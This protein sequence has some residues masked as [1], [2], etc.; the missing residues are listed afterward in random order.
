MLA[1]QKSFFND[2]VNSERLH[3][4]FTFVRNS[5]GSYFNKDGV[6]VYVAN[7]IPRIEFDPITKKCLGVKVEPTA[8]NHLLNSRISTISRV[9]ITDGWYML[10][11]AT[12]GTGDNW[13][14]GAASTKITPGSYPLYQ[15]SYTSSVRKAYNDFQSFSIFAKPTLG[16]Q[17][18]I[19]LSDGANQLAFAIYEFALDGTATLISESYAEEKLIGNAGVEKVRKDGWW[20]LSL[21]AMVPSA[22]TT[23]NIS[24][25]VIFDGVTEV[26]GS[27]LENMPYCTSYIRTTTST[28]LRG[29][30]NINIPAATLSNFTSPEGFTIVTDFNNRTIANCNHIVAGPSLVYDSLHRCQVLVHDFEYN[31]FV[32]QLSGRLAGNGQ[33]LN[34]RLAYQTSRSAWK[35]LDRVKS[36][37]GVGGGRRAAL[38][39]MGKTSVEFLEDGDFRNYPP[40]MYLGTYNGTSAVS[41]TTTAELAVSGHFREIGII[42]NRVS[43][44]VLRALSHQ[45]IDPALYS[46][47]GFVQPIA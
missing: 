41:P 17:V 24:I 5:E 22:N 3:P 37:L 21:M 1:P 20:R 18:M 39:M 43:D 6:L 13:V 34:A 33:T 19:E 25:R 47:F 2:I 30:D 9:G 10:G 38:A 32:I 11:N 26:N 28:A 29:V 40:S 12:V 16:K 46:E 45:E 4:I 7:N 8:T 15:I 44:R 35:R 36:A 14:D 27:Q 42:P 23:S 31:T